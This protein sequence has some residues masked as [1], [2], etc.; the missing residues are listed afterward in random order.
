MTESPGFLTIDRIRQAE[1]GALAGAPEGALM[2]KAALAVTRL[3]D[4]LLQRQRRPAPVSALVGPGNNGADALLALMMLASRGYAVRAFAS[5]TDRRLPP[6]AARV[7]AQWLARGGSFTALDR[8][9]DHLPALSHR[10]GSHDGGLIIDGL[11]GIGLQRPLQGDAAAAAQLTHR[12]DSPVIAV[13]VPSGLNASTG[14]IVGGER[15]A[16]VCASHT[17]TMIANK[18]G[19]H[20]GTGKE[21]AGAV[22]L[23]TLDVDPGPVDGLLIDQSWVGA[24]LSV[25]KANTHKGSFGFVAILGGAATM[26]GASLLAGH[27]ARAAGAGKVALISPDRAVF[28]AGSPQL[29][30]WQANHP[31]QLAEQLK[32]VNTL[33]AGCGLGT[34]PLAGVLLATGLGGSVAAVLDADALNLLASPSDAPPLGRLL[35]ERAATSPTV[36]TPHPLEAARLLRQTVAQVQNDRIGAALRLAAQTRCTV[37]LKGAGSIIAAPDGRHAINTSGGPALATGGTGDLLAGV[38]GGLLAQGHTAWEAA[39]IGTWVHGH[40]ADRWTHEHPRATGLDANHLIGQLISV[41]NT[42]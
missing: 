31:S 29:M 33:V 32:P 4:R 17:V 39:A 8:L 42:C 2:R 36:L 34:E 15:A 19:L 22:S 40:A 12:L 1:T 41:F 11:F 3:A 27:G 20:T 25:R 10:D 28:D 38:I 16:V 30:A 23:A 24:R 35:N 13:D 5:P 14:A 21:V 7:H 6:D 37:V 18:P 26:P 9:P